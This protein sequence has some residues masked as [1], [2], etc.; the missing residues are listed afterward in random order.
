METV[1]TAPETPH[2]PQGEAASAW[3]EDIL[4]DMRALGEMAE[5]AM[6]VA[7][8][9]AQRA[10]RGELSDA[11]AG[12]DRVT[13][14]VRRTIALK[15]RLREELLAAMQGRYVMPTA[16]AVT[17]AAREKDPLADAMRPARDG[18]NLLGDLYDSAENGDEIGNTPSGEVYRSVCRDL[19]VTPDETRFTRDGRTA[20]VVSG[21]VAVVERAP[22]TAGRAVPDWPRRAG[23]GRDPPRSG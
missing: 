6:V 11:V 20:P 21:D 2:T 22:E 10:T 8:D 18:I 3:V 4:G 23:N 12:I 9:L 15:M 5:C 16:R 19:G 1:A 7:R 13:R 17:V 14:S